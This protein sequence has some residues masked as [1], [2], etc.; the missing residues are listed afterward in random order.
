MATTLNRGV[1]MLVAACVAVAALGAPGTA[2]AAKSTKSD[3]QIARAGLFVAG[4]VPS[5]W[6]AAA[7]PTPDDKSFDRLTR[8]TPSCAPTVKGRAAL[9]KG[10]AAKSVDFTLAPD[11]MNDQVWV[12][13]RVGDATKAFAQLADESVSVC[14]TEALDQLFTTELASASLQDVDVRVRKSPLL[15]TADGRTIGDEAFILA[16][17]VRIVPTSG[18]TQTVS[19]ISIF[20]RTGSAITNYV[21]GSEPTSTGQFSNATYSAFLGAVQAAADRLRAAQA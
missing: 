13:D 9:Q 11:T 3:R 7:K 18:A 5:S 19:V 21:L 17:A 6:Q 15:P 8:K 14:Y 2:G 1:G 16:V 10:T 20:A 4:D 12:L